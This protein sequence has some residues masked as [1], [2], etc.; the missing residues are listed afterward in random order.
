MRKVLPVL[1]V[2]LGSFF[3]V[4]AIV[5]LT[6]VPGQ[7]ERTPLDTDNTTALSGTAGVFSGGDA[8]EEG[9]VLAWSGNAVDSEASDD[10]NVVFNTSLCLVHD[11]G[12]IDSCV[13][14]DDPEGR[15][16]SAETQ[17]FVAD[18]HTAMTVDNGDYLPE[19]APQL[20]GLQNKWPFNAEK[21]TYPVWDDIVAGTVDAKYVDEEKIDGLTVYKYEY[22]AHATG[23]ELV[24]DITG[25]YDATYTF[26][27][28]PR[29]GSIIKQVVHQERVADDGTPLLELDLAFTDDQVKTNVDDANDARATLRL[30]EDIVP[31]VGLAVGIPFVLAGL[32]LLV[33]G[34]RKRA[35][36]ARTDGRSTTTVG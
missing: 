5:A 19:T 27:I 7:V 25:T 24:A 1:L 4:V 26:Y 35:A 3:V 36:A 18:R 11:E 16:I 31:V 10:D 34:R 6:W 14:K 32:A 9:P 29:T 20:A 2:T 12:G 21:K 30:L 33:L 8:L 22:V 28:E 17:Q 13:D 23:V 15:L